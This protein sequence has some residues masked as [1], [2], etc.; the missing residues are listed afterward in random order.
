MAL[1]PTDMQQQC[2]D[3]HTRENKKS[4]M[5]VE[6]RDFHNLHICTPYIVL[7]NLYKYEINGEWLSLTKYYCIS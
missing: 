5:Q 6:R 7:A 4:I 1:T 3:T 2:K